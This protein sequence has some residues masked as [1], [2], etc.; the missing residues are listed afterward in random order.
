M[1][2]L[3]LGQSKIRLRLAKKKNREIAPQKI[4]TLL[5]FQINSCIGCY[6]LARSIFLTGHISTYIY[7]CAIW[8][9]FLALGNSAL[10]SLK[11]G[12]S[13][14]RWRLTNVNKFL[15]HD[16]FLYFLVFISCTIFVGLFLFS[17]NGGRSSFVK[18]HSI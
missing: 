12:Q 7:F 5:T 18:T 6:L 2:P 17:V 11:L 16:F 8:R 10:C 14:I 15:F 1:S 4:F 9:I 3:K 13:E